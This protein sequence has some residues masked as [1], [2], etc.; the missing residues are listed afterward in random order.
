MRKAETATQKAVLCESGRVQPSGVGLAKT[1]KDS[2]IEV[3]V[4]GRSFDLRPHARDNVAR[5]EV[6]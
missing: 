6:K 2:W 5:F 3:Q 1:P 4:R